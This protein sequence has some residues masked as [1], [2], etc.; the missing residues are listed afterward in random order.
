M[1]NPVR[2]CN[3]RREGEKGRSDLLCAITEYEYATTKR[4]GIARKTASCYY[5]CVF[6]LS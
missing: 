5:Y 3:V 2:H 1:Y 6:N 4:L